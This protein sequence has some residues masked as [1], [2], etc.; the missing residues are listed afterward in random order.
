MEYYMFPYEFDYQLGM[1]ET[2][3]IFDP[4]HSHD[5]IEWNEVTVKLKKL[6]PTSIKNRI[7]H[8]DNYIPL[9]FYGKDNSLWAG[10]F[11][12][13]SYNDNTNEIT[14]KPINLL[15]YSL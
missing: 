11:L 4:K 14:M 15:Q 12:L 6:I 5:R 10:N 8:K 9:Y 1:V 7:D 3:F 2:D 13:K